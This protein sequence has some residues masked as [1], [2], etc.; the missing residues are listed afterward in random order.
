MESFLQ[1]AM[2]K[3]NPETVQP[4]EKEEAPVAKKE[5]TKVPINRNRIAYKQQTLST[6]MKQGIP[7][8]QQNG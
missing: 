3:M 1:K 7:E 2:K 8:E 6:I 5:K 4:V